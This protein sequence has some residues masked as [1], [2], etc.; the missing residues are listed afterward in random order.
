MSEVEELV[1]LKAS[2]PTSKVCLT[3]KRKLPL[4]GSSVARENGCHS[5][6]SERPSDNIMV[7]RDKHDPPHEELKSETEQRSSLIPGCVIC[8]VRGNLLEC[9]DCHSG[10]VSSFS[11]MNVESEGK[12]DSDSTRSLDLIST[13]SSMERS[14]VSVCDTGSC[15]LKEPN[16]QGSNSLAE[17]TTMDH[18]SNLLG[19]TKSMSLITFSRRCRRKKDDGLADPKI[20]FPEEKNCSFLINCSSTADNLVSKVGSA[21][22][23]IDIELSV[24]GRDSRHVSHRNQDNVR[25][26]S[27][28]FHVEN[29]V[30]TMILKC[31]EELSAT[32]DSPISEREQISK[33]AVDTEDG[34]LDSCSQSLLDNAAKNPCEP[35]AV[36]TMLEDTKDRDV[37]E[38]L[39]RDDEKATTFADHMKGPQPRLDL[40]VTP[41]SSH[42]LESCINLDLGCRKDPVNASGSLQNSTDSISRSHATVSD[43]ASPAELLEC[44][45]KRDRESSPVHATMALSDASTSVEEARNNAEDKFGARLASVV[46]NESKYKYLQLF[47]EEKGNCFGLAIAKPEDDTSMVLEEIKSL[48]LGSNNNQTLQTS[49]G[50]PLDLG[51]SLPTGSSIGNQSSKKCIRASPVRYS[52]CKI[53]DFIQEAVPQSSSNHSALLL[54]HKLMLDSIVNRASALN[55]KGGFQEKF[56]PYTTLWSEEELD[57]L[58]IGVRRHGRDNWL[59]MLRDPRLRFSSWRTARDLA[60]QWE[61]EQ[62]KLLNGTRVKFKSSSRLDISVDN[63]GFLC[64]KTGIWR[65]NYTEETRLS[66]GDVYAHRTGGRISKR[67]RYSF[68]GVENDTELLHRPTSYPRTAPY[69]DFQGEIYSKVSHDQLGYMNVPMFDSLLINSPFTALTS[70]GNLPH[71]LREVVNTPLRPTEATRTPSFS[72]VAHS[73]TIRTNKP[74]QDPSE[75]YPTDLRMDSEFGSARA[76]DPTTYHAGVS[77]AARHGNTDISNRGS[78]GPVIKP[79]NLIIIDCD[80]SSE[81]TISDDHSDR[82]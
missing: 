20:P 80:A 10:Q 48:N 16:L 29:A 69:S 52:D 8:G 13:K 31:E 39:S 75:F 67:R 12:L 23:A 42:T 63:G 47:S 72:S 41:D 82:P 68:T 62:A 74:Y 59:S 5:S 70:K 50:S 81:E 18:S 14:C 64:P 53:R 76:I 4:S 33:A 15:S 9:R 25:D 77:L 55:S 46:D 3:Y 37:S 43:Q 61:E 49:C 35:I 36:D 11:A 56:K 73:G 22:N 45:N 79:D 32:D 21:D 28:R 38:V 40:S 34:R 30:E 17:V 27:S 44:M 26:D 2:M 51:L 6:L 60:E 1:S 66:L 24:E 57:F 78:S 65:E 58:W 19:Q 7:E 71:W 54:R